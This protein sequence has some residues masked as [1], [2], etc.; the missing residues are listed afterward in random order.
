M[1][2][3]VVLPTKYGDFDVWTHKKDNQ[4]C[5]VISKNYGSDAPFLRLHSSCV[6]SEALLANDCDCAQQLHLSLEFIGK[7]GGIVIYSYEEGRGIGLENKIKA[8]KLEKQENINTAQAFKILGFEPDPRTYDLAIDA[9]LSLKIDKVR[10]ATNNPKKL[11][12]LVKNGIEIVERIQ[13]NVTKNPSVKEY[14]AKK[15]DCLGHYDGED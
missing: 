8:I 3:M 7:N 12:A 14:L 1:D 9:I 15:V 11:E 13:L 4:Q 10:V 5:M 2:D 6:F